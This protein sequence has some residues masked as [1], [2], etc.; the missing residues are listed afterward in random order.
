VN[1]LKMTEYQW[2]QLKEEREQ[3]IA[4]ALYGA[5]LAGQDRKRCDVEFVVA[6][7]PEWWQIS[8][9]RKQEGWSLADYGQSA[10]L[11]MMSGYFVREK[12]EKEETKP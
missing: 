5:L 10:S 1:G 2:E 8:K 12:C 3:Q 4:H 6:G 7:W 11:F 9:R